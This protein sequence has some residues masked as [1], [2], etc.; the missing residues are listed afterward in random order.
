MEVADFDPLKSTYHPSLHAML[1]VRHSEFWD[2]T[3]GPFNRWGRYKDG[4]RHRLGSRIR[5]ITCDA[6]RIQRGHSEIISP[7]RKVADD[8]ARD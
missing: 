3:V 6:S 8:V 7:W 5:G 1:P 2:G 4:L